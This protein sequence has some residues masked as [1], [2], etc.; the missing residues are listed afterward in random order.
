MKLFSL[1]LLIAPMAVSASTP[2]GIT[3]GE[4]IAKYGEV[5]KRESYCEVKTDH[6]PKNNSIAKLY[7]LVQEPGKGLVKVVM[8]THDYSAHGVSFKTDFHEIKDSLIDSGYHTLAF[9]PGELS[10]Y[11]CVLQGLCNGKHWMAVDSTGV[12]VSLEQKM[13]GRDHAFI[14]LEFESKDYVALENTHL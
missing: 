8:R 13:V 9:S 7:K 5:T 2:F 6:L 12:T 4:D 3:W 11:Q 10:S 1:L 14:N